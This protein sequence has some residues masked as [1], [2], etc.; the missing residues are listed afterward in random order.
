MEKKQNLR[1]NQVPAKVLLNS[2]AR[3]SNQ[4]ASGKQQTRNSRRRDYSS[5]FSQLQ[6]KTD[7]SFNNQY[8]QQ[9][10]QQQQQQQQHQY[11][12]F[13]PKSRGGNSS[14]NYNAYG[15][16]AGDAKRNS[17]RGA[18]CSNNNSTNG[19]GSSGGSN[20]ANGYPRI[21]SSTGARL[22][23]DDDENAEL[24][25]SDFE[26]ELNSVYLPGSKKQ[27]LNHLLNFN[28]APRERH[29]STTFMRSGN[30]NKG[31]HAYVK[32]IKYNKEQFLQANCQ[33]V[34]KSTGNY[35]P[36]AISPDQLVEWSSIEQINFFGGT[37]ESQC[38]I[39]LYHPVAAKMTRCGHVY[40]WPCILHYLAL[41]DK[42]SWRKCPICY[43]AVHIGDLKSAVLKPH[44]SYN[45]GESVTFQLMCRQKNSLQVYN[46]EVAAQIKSKAAAAAAIQQFPSLSDPIDHLKH[47]KL[48]LAQSHE[49]MT[50][51][52]R[53]RRELKC[54]LVSDGMDC[55]DS[56]F[57]QQALNLLE[58]RE[59][60][61][62]VELKVSNDQ[63]IDG[64]DDSAMVEQMLALNVDAKE[65]IPVD[66]HAVR[67][68]Q[69]S[70]DSADFVID[71]DTELTLKDIAIV[72]V[73]SATNDDCFYFYQANDGQHLY[74][75]SINIRMLQTMY[76]A[77]ERAPKTIV[78]RILQKESCSMTAELR[79]R[80]KYL[81]HLPVTCQFDVV[82][83]ELTS[84][85]IVSDEIAAKF[86]DELKQRQK[87]RQRRAREERL[88]EKHIDR[89]NERRIGKIIHSAANIDVTSV[90]EFPTCGSFDDA[91]FPV[92]N[93]LQ[94][95]THEMDR[96]ASGSGTSTASSGPS[97]A[98]MLTSPMSANKV[99][100]WPTLGRPKESP[101]AMQNNPMASPIKGASASDTY[102]A[103]SAPNGHIECSD[104]D[105]I[106]AATDDLEALYA[107]PEFN[108]SF[109]QSIADALNKAAHSK[110][111]RKQQHQ[112]QIDAGRCCTTAA[113][114]KKKNAKKTTVLFSTGS[115]T[116]DGK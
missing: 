65:F 80:L 53:E 1:T 74:L 106:D 89:E 95:Q 36:Y 103:S 12:L 54:Q 8:K 25:T 102:G 48:V 21:A 34:V 76:G 100:S 22:N 60:G 94:S 82:E 109:G 93:P 20:N 92:P 40:C 32:R 116:F 39:C 105:S 9:S 67:E 14:T 31:G 49:I 2:D 87:N 56:I 58:D 104:E 115:H 114:K 16:G 29:D 97:F 111:P 57:V 11:Q 23:A 18:G 38:P 37:E 17:G 79:K 7:R 96:M 70:D 26:I 27:N 69:N 72:P 77:L 64:T 52:E 59:N 42:K 98:K 68:R 91:S 5:N 107:R 47:S 110:N 51:I 78:G 10:Q 84:P 55:P 88:R 85:D 46:A 3:K 73:E 63:N 33:F 13:A 44:H 41:S 28:Y 99:E 43:E 86:K 15:S 45:C 62:R 113:G 19:D 75:H 83:I 30:I 66:V 50:I 61:I 81:Q 90:H 108:E 4:D 6:S 35:E 71:A 24:F 112:Q 101:F